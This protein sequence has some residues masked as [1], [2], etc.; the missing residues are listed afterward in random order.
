MATSRRALHCSFHD[1]RIAPGI[2]SLGM[3]GNISL[4]SSS[5]KKEAS[6]PGFKLSTKISRQ[7]MAT[8]SIEEGRLV[9]HFHSNV[10]HLPMRHVELLRKC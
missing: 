10:K 6:E 4:I 5:A 9:D 2:Y 1:Q 7:S 3:L 8:Y